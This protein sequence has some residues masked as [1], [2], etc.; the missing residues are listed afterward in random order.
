MTTALYVRTAAMQSKIQVGYH[1][2][3]RSPLR[4][5]QWLHLIA[6]NILASLG[7][8]THSRPIIA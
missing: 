4:A 1:A 7:Y 8:H 5:Q 6:M 3:T 2:H